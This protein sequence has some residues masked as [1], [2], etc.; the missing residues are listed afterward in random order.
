MTRY[1][2]VCG[3]KI[4]AQF[5]LVTSP[6]VNKSA[7]HFDFPSCDSHF[8]MTQTETYDSFYEYTMNMGYSPHGPIHGWVGGVGGQSRAAPG[9]RCTRRA[10]SPTRSSWS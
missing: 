1:H 4:N 10:R 6:Y 5:F 3:A 8:Q 2:K 7:D 9:T